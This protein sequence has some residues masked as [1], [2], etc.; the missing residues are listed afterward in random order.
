MLAALFRRRPSLTIVPIPKQVQPPLFK[1]NPPWW[2]RW[3]LVLVAVD[4]MTASVFLTSKKLCLLIPF[5]SGS[6]MELTWN[7]WTVS[8]DRKKDATNKTGALSEPYKP[9]LQPVWMRSAFCLLHFMSGCA[10]AG[11][12]LAFRSR[13]VRSI[14]VPQRSTNPTVGLRLYLETAGHPPHHGHEINLKRCTLVESTKK[15]L[16]IEVNGH[17]RWLLNFRGA[18]INGAP[19]ALS[20]SLNYDSMLEAWQILRQNDTS[21]PSTSKIPKK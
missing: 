10:I 16:F 11:Y 13:I 15:Q 1:K 8:P 9:V 7:Y 3:A 20:P 2:A 12:I 4:V 17:G 14:T 18:S 19:A 21:F 5:Y 6:A